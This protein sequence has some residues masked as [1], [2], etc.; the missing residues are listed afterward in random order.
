[1]SEIIRSLV[2]RAT[3]AATGSPVPAIG[4][5]KAQQKARKAT[6]ADRIARGA[7]PRATVKERGTKG[8]SGPEQGQGEEAG[9]KEPAETVEEERRI[10]RDENGEG[11][12]SEKDNAGAGLRGEGDG[13]ANTGKEAVGASQLQSLDLGSFVKLQEQ[14]YKEFQA[15]RGQPAEAPAPVR[16]NE[17]EERPGA[18]QVF[19]MVR[20]DACLR[21]HGYFETFEAKWT[22]SVAEA[23]VADR[24]LLVGEAISA[25]MP[26]YAQEAKE[27]A[28]TVIYMR[29][30]RV[31]YLR[32]REQLIQDLGGLGLTVDAI[33]DISFAGLPAEG[34]TFDTAVAYVQVTWAQAAIEHIW[35]FPPKL[36]D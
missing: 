1:M 22:M 29:G 27:G 21:T 31:S 20:Q 26:K 24:E 17:S 6:E 33:D 35:K 3:A 8:S 36:W 2:G 25:P 7:E 14:R 13:S 12:N 4:K 11:A 9:A 15:R 28:K 19:E 18:M 23:L 32:Q 30:I 16:G 10:D 34:S 5:A